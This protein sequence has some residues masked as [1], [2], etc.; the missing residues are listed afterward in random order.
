M[1]ADKIFSR[2]VQIKKGIALDNQNNYTEIRI[3]DRNKK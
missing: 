1:P 2:P 3:V